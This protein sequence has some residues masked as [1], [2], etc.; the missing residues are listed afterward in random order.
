M[1][2][3]Q[4]FCGILVMLVWE[5]FGNFPK[6]KGATVQQQ[7]SIQVR[8]DA[9]VNVK[10][11]RV[12]ITFGV[13]TRGPQ[14]LAARNSNQSI[15]AKTLAELKSLK[16]RPQDIQTDHQSVEPIYSGS[17]GQEQLTGYTVRSMLVVTLSDASQLDEVMT[18]ALQAGVNVIRGVQFETSELRRYRDQAREIALK[19]AKEK[20][21]NMAAV[22]GM[23][24]GQALTISE[25]RSGSSWWHNSSWYG[26]GRSSAAMSQNVVQNMP[27]SSDTLEGEVH[28]GQISVQASVEVS[29]ELIAGK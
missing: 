13:E 5:G 29:F 11:D 28:L 1:R 17:Y 18:R 8:G 10:P 3:D 19:A 26:W 15:V 21:E 24:V 4:L 22:L 16:V 25:G 14:L 23:R 27:A 12:V 7:R 9:L 6:A 20:A 2:P